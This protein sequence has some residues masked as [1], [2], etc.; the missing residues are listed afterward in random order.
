MFMGGWMVVPTRPNKT[1]RFNLKFWNI[2][3]ERKILRHIVGSGTE[4][5]WDRATRILYVAFRHA[6]ICVP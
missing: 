2:W 6:A 4:L 1:K 5:P 3:A